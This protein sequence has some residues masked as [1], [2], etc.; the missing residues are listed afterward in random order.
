MENGIY[1]T[2]FKSGDRFD[3][4]NYRGINDIS[5]VGKLFDSI[6]N[7]RLETYLNENKIISE[8]QIGFQKKARTTDH[9][10]VLRTLIEKYTKQN[11]NRLFTC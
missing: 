11:K 8:T 1:N 9:M 4:L 5:C 3:S 7:N 6:L 10:F 2:Y